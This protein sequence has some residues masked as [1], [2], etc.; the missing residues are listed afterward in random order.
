MK[1]IELMAV[2]QLGDDGSVVEEKLTKF[3]FG[4][5]ESN[6]DTTIYESKERV[7]PVVQGRSFITLPDF[8]WILG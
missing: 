5:R 7:Q 4:H 1:E 8:P 2:T 6:K 3:P